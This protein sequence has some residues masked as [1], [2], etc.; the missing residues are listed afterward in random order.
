M[1]AIVMEEKCTFDRNA[2]ISLNAGVLSFLFDAK[3]RNVRLSGMRR[4][5]KIGLR[6]CSKISFPH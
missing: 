3:E 2:P 4:E 6:F 1:I 5:C